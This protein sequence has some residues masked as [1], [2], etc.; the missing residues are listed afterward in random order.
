MVRGRD[1]PWLISEIRSKMRKRDFLLKKAKA[2]GKAVDWMAHKKLR[3]NITCAIRKSKANYHRY[4]FN[5]NINIRGY[6]KL[7]LL[8]LS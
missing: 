5:E 2:S 6:S 3:N 7:E 1:C 8:P 4:F